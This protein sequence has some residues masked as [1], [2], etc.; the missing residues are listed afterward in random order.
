M[1]DDTVELTFTHPR[2]AVTEFVL[3]AFSYVPS[4]F[5]L[6]RSRAFAQNFDDA[7]EAV[8]FYP[9][10]TVAEYGT[11]IGEEDIMA[12]VFARGPVACEIDATPLHDYT[13]RL[14]AIWFLSVCPFIVYRIRRGQRRKERGMYLLQC[15]EVG[16]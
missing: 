15:F 8:A 12:E 1:H 14:Q 9:N 13:V 4:S 6:G 11:V 16:R 2:D 5:F 10:A 3:A 7:C